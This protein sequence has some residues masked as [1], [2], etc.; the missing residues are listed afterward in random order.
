MIEAFPE[1]D[2]PAKSRCQVCGGE[3]RRTAVNPQCDLC[4]SRMW[5]RP[6]AGRTSPRSSTVINNLMRKPCDRSW[7]IYDRHRR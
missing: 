6:V 5:Q 1:T 4:R 2:A 7:S 3:G